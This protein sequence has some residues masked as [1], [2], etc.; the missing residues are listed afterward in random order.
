MADYLLMISRTLSYSVILLSFCMKLPQI[1]AI[2]S[3]K[4]SR[5]VHIRGTWMELAR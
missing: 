3:A 5:G 4:S 1:S 2:Y